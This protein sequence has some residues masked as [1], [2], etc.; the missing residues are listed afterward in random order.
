M[1]LAGCRIGRRFL[2][3]EGVS[4]FFQFFGK[5]LGDLSQPVVGR[6]PCNNPISHGSLTQIFATVHRIAGKFLLRCH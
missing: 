4:M 6:L 3:V 1:Q 2:A 5:L